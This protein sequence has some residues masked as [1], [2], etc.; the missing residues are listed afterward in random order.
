MTD[1]AVAAE[2][3]DSI[4]MPQSHL[5]PEDIAHIE[6]HHNEV[7]GIHLVPGLEVEANSTTDGID[8]RITVKEGIAIERPVH[9]CFGMLPEEGLQYINMVISIEQDAQ[10]SVLAHCT[11]PN[12]KKVVH[13]MDAE[14]V[15][16]AGARYSY[17]ERH[18][19]GSNDGVDVVPKAKITVHEGAEFT[20][21]FE[22]IKGRAGR[23]DFEYEATCHAG[24]I[25][26][27]VTRIRGSKNDLIRINEIAH[28][29]GESARAALI[30]NIAVRDEARAEVYNTLT[31]SGPRARGHVDCKEVVVGNAQAIAVPA[32]EVK[33]PL[34]HVTHE[35]AI[36][37]VDSKQLETLLT[38]GL[39][40]DEATE[41]I[42]DGLLTRS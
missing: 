5:L 40:E 8:A 6:I 32:V 21:E 1:N 35:A 25:L 4:G 39:T 24:S 12:A 38:R 28:L 18:V 10:V 16:A 9:L 31:A 42:I 3:L 14:I 13:K 22:L 15:V 27:M 2:L 34:A 26:E 17:F 33:H 11:F 29:V 23:I 30:S 41:M 37:S 7:V 20:T 36:G 19:H